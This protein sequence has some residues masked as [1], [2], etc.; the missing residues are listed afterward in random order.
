MKYYITADVH[1]FYTE[2]RKPLN[3]AGYFID[4]GPRKLI[5][6]GDLFDHGQEALQ[7][8]QFILQFMEQDDV[9]LVRETTKISTRK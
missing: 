2:F 6:L 4:P 8:Q 5:I 7:M 3:E 9:I 1:G